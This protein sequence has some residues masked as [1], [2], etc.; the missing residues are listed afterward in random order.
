MDK[1]EL[2]LKEPIK[3]H[4]KG[5]KS[6]RSSEDLEDERGQKVALPTK[7]IKKE[8]TKEK[9]AEI[10]KRRKNYDKS[11]DSSD[12]DSSFDDRQLPVMPNR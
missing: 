7:R 9:L 8:L 3:I 6:R 2:L 5:Q 4:K 10:K 12:S 11:E 1:R